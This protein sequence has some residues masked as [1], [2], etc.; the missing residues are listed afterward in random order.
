MKPCKIEYVINRSGVL[1]Y[2]SVIQTY[3][4]R[5]KENEIKRF[6]LLPF[7]FAAQTAYMCSISLNIPP[8]MRNEV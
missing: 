8:K 3:K 1:F 7:Y 2:Q 6:L 4:N 5:Q